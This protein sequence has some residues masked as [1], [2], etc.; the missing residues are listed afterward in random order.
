M[1]WGIVLWFADTFL[2]VCMISSRMTFPVPL[3][4]P[5]PWGIEILIALLVIGL[6]WGGL[7]LLCNGPPPSVSPK[8]ETKKDGSPLKGI[9]VIFFVFFFVIGYYNRQEIFGRLSTKEYVPQ[10]RQDTPATQ[11]SVSM[12]NSDLSPREL[13]KDEETQPTL[14]TIPPET[15]S[16]SSS[17][18]VA[19]A[20]I[21]T[22]PVSV[23]YDQTLREMMR[24]GKYADLYVDEN[25]EY[26]PS[27]HRGTSRIEM[28]I[29]NF[30]DKVGY[31][32][33]LRRLDK[34]NLRPASCRSYWLSM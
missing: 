11:P 31:K 7:R 10:T 27:S 29:V 28:A 5:E 32:E 21:E 16:E 8:V 22:S 12:P 6:F 13:P 19:S 3:N 23:N 4:Q 34:M 2:V 18:T 26:P 17:E 9:A 24:I 33:V 20:S 14:T 1:F 25:S 15:I 30:D